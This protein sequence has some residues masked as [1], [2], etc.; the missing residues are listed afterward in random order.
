MAWQTWLSRRSS[1]RAR[2]RCPILYLHQS[3]LT[4]FQDFLLHFTL[5]ASKSSITHGRG[6]RFWQLAKNDIPSLEK[7]STSFIKRDQRHKTISQKI[8]NCRNKPVKLLNPENKR[9]EKEH[10]ANNDLKC[11]TWTSTSFFPGPNP[12][13]VLQGLFLLG[14]LDPHADVPSH[15]P[16]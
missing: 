1:S 9:D 10:S 12:D 5:K 6:I 3:W 14:V 16:D 8:Y 11:I 4:F 13:E 7:T 2:V 15:A